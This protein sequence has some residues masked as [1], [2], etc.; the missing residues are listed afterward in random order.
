MSHTPLNRSNFGELLGAAS[1]M[2]FGETTPTP[3]PWLRLDALSL[4]YVC[5]V[6][7]FL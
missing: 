1:V 7:S 3:L 5:D 4:K 6:L 2:V